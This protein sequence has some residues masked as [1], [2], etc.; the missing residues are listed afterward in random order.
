MF[1][2]KNNILIGKNGQTLKALQTMIRQH[3][4][5][6]INAYPYIILDVENY[7]EKQVKHL[8]FLAKKLAKEVLSTKQPIVMDNMNS[9]ERRVVHN[10]LTKFK[11]IDTTS[12][13]E[14]P[15][16]HIVIKLK[17]D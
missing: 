15:N 13:G 12:E 9:Y 17:E 1:S 11:D 3:I 5:R 4:Y 2:D 14:E 10:A 16:R 7:K 8:E 6:E